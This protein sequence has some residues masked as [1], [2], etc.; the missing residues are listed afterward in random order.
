MILFQFIVGI[1]WTFVSSIKS[2]LLIT[3][4]QSF[5][6][7]SHCTNCSIIISVIA[8]VNKS[9]IGLKRY[10]DHLCN[11]SFWQNNLNSRFDKLPKNKKKKSE[12]TKRQWRKDRKVYI[13]LQ[14]AQ[15]RGPTDNHLLSLWNNIFI[16]H[17]SRPLH[18]SGPKEKLHVKCIFLRHGFCH[19]S[20]FV[21][22]WFMYVCT[23]VCFSLVIWCYK[24]GCNVMIDS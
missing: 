6:N 20:W 19:F 12:L 11:L 21:S 8:T 22:H 14:R 24:I 17:N 1:I 23:S 13:R 5:Y 4:D 2:C 15:N 16:G 10:G 9:Y 18:V 3:V 7:F